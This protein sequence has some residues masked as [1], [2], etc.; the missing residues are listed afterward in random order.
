MLISTQI[1]RLLLYPAFLDKTVTLCSIS[2]PPNSLLNLAD[3]IPTPFIIM[4]DFHA[5]S[6]LWGTKSTNDKGKKLKD[7]ISQDGLCILIDN[8][9]AYLHPGNGYYSAIDL[10][11]T[12]PS[13][14][15]NVSWKVYDD[16]CGSDHFLLILESL[17]LLLVK[18]LHIILLAK[19]AGLC[20]NR[21]AEKNFK[22]K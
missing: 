9:D 11:V 5:H 17:N 15:L 7:F 1:Y 4:G 10:T 14:L 3:Q 19:L 12:D 2:I 6:P 13:F 22:R 21:C 16:L 18:H 8:T 20:T